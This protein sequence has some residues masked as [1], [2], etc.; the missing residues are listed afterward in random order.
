ML[1]LKVCINPSSW[2]R[3]LFVMHPDMA[4][5]SSSLFVA[6]IPS[7]L[8]NDI[9]LSISSIFKIL[10]RRLDDIYQT[11]VW[12]IRVGS[13][14]SCGVLG[15]LGLSDEKTQICVAEPPLLLCLP[16]TQKCFLK[17]IGMLLSPDDKQEHETWH[18][19]AHNGKREAAQLSGG[20]NEHLNPCGDRSPYFTK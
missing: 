16:L 2:S 10:S 17:G 1:G 18:L 12:P 6:W 8:N 4:F 3:S 11:E 15:D 19:R 7:L 5:T 13:D 9:W 20:F 14:S